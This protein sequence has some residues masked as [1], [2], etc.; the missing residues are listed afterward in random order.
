[1]FAGAPGHPLSGLDQLSRANLAPRRKI[2]EIEAEG[3][4]VVRD[5]QAAEPWRRESSGKLPVAEPRADIVERRR[6]VPGLFQGAYG[7]RQPAR[8]E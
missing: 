5:L 4:A 3:A 2:D 7:F 8:R 1:M 6:R